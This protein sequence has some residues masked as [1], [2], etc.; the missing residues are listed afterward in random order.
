M[1]KV[2]LKQQLEAFEKGIFLNSDRKEDNRGY[3][4]YD[5]FCMEKSLKSKAEKLFKISKRFIK[6]YNIDVEN[7]Y[8]FFKNNCPINGPTY[9]DFR[10]CDVETGNVI[11]T[12]IPK[13][14]HTGKA[15]VWGKEN[16]FEGPIIVGANMNEIYKT[17]Q[18]SN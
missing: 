14:G 9:D 11:F 17:I 15:E 4:F 6:Q 10:I 1:I 2:N 13:S 12:V 16:N 7:T 18:L 5:W 8:I 3:N